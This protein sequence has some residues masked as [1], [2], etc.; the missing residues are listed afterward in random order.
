MLLA[1]KRTETRNSSFEETAGLRDRIRRTQAEM[2]IRGLRRDTP[3][4]RSLQ[5]ARLDQVRLDD[6]LDRPP[7]LADRDREA[8]DADG[9]AVETLDDRQEELAVHRIET[10]RIDLEQI[11][12]R[13]RDRRVDP[14]VRLD[15]RIVPHA[16]DEPVGDP[17][18]A[19]RAGGD[20][21]RAPRIDR[22]IQD[23]RRAPRDLRELLDAVEV[24]VL[25]DAESVAQR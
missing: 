22:Q 18:G 21:P 12:C 1:P 7:L 17:R 16:P 19:A 23:A 25:R 9:A 8:F 20:L 13:F 5:E 24:E 4:G 2:P 15:L 11:H 14:S 10:V 6:V 3:A